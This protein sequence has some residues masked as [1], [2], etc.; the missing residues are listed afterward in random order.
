MRIS[1]LYMPMTHV[2]CLVFI[3]DSLDSLVEHVNMKL[4][5]IFNWCNDNKLSLNPTK[6]ELMVVTSKKVALSQLTNSS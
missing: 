3:G 5:N 1:T 4:A 2:Y 6:C